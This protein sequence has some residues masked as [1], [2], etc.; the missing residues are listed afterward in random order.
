MRRRERGMLIPGDESN[1]A[2]SPI[3]ILPESGAVSPAMQ[4]SSVVFPAPEAPKR[5]VNPADASKATSRRKSFAL[6]L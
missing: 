2:R 5:I 6:A 4:S 3:A 1:S